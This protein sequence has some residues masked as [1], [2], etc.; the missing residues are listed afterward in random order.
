MT[1]GYCI[2]DLKPGMSASFGKTVTDAD[3]VM[4]AGISGD[5]NPVHL[6]QTFAEQT[7]FKARIAHGLLSAGFISAVLGTKLPGPG[8][9]YMSQNLRFKAP[10][11][12][13]D[14]VTATCTV[15]EVIPEKRRAVLSTICKVGETVVIEGEAMIMVP[16][17]SK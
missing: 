6:D 12:I 9:I 5:T 4:F 10:V 17:R 13:G 8:A 2:E 15:T 7:P 11:K 16:S 3:I 14:T 1:A